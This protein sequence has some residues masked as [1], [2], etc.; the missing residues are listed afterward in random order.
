MK[1]II[2]L[3][4]LT[5]AFGYVGKAQENGKSAPQMT[6]SLLVNESKDQDIT[7]LTMKDM[8]ELSRTLELQ[9]D[10]QVNLTNLLMRRNEDLSKLADE[11][12]KKVL[13]EIYGEKLLG[14][15]SEKQLQQIK[16]N[17]NKDL[18]LRLTQ[19]TSK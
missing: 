15:L 16:T 17:K 12:E 2:T 6:S 19:Y 3:L 9:Q 11:G 10:E 18:Y 7:E 8:A 1:K 13:F 4:A 14:S 5:L